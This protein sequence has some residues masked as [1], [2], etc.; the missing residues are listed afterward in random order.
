MKT[1]EEDLAKLNANHR[2]VFNGYRTL[3]A[4]A[5]ALSAAAKKVAVLHAAGGGS[6]DQ[7]LNATKEMQEMNQSF[8]RQYVQL[9]SRIQVENQRYVALSS[10]MKTKH[11]TAK[12]AISN[13]R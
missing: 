4:K 10:L 8:S 9:K 7:L 12:N 2:A 6:K 5:E 1:L 13:I 3:A 11:D